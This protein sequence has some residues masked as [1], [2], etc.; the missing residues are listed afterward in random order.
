MAEAERESKERREKNLVRKIPR[1]REVRVRSSSRLLSLKRREPA[2]K[3]PHLLVQATGRL[4]LDEIVETAGVDVAVDLRV[5]DHAEVRPPDEVRRVRG[6]Y[7]TINCRD[8]P[9]AAF[10]GFHHDRRADGVGFIRRE[11]ARVRVFGARGPNGRGSA[12]GCI[13][14]LGPARGGGGGGQCAPHCGPRSTRRNSPSQSRLARMT[15]YIG[16]IM[17]VVTIIASMTSSSRHSTYPPSASRMDLT[18]LLATPLLPSM[19]S[20]SSS[21]PPSSAEVGDGA[22]ADWSRAHPPLLDMGGRHISL[23]TE[24][25]RSPVLPIRSSTLLVDCVFEVGTLADTGGRELC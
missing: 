5:L 7:S 13:H 11:R 10:V 24:S 2:E 6:G 9:I 23:Y 3:D 4:L 1:K 18:T 21:E 22:G 20:R 19:D 8:I 12:G 16:P 14:R 15:P 25:R 17:Q